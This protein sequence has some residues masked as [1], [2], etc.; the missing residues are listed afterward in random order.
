MQFNERVV[1]LDLQG[2]QVSHFQLLIILSEKLCRVL[3]DASLII[4]LNSHSCKPRA[5]C[6]NRQ[7]KLHFM[8]I[9]S[10]PP[11]SASHKCEDANL[12]LTYT[13]TQT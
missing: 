6:I 7:V 1:A 10:P 8:L 2:H 4:Y 9:Y 11:P 5:R 12:A 3:L 13:F